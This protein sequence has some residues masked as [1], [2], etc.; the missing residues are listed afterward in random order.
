MLGRTE[1]AKGGKSRINPRDLAWHVDRSAF[2]RQ[3]RPGEEGLYSAVD[4]RAWA[5]ET[6][7]ACLLPSS[8]HTDHG[9]VS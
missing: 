1:V 4:V 5:L 6:E 7:R 3:G 9:Q 8:S 2:L